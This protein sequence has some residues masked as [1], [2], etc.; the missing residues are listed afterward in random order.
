MYYI[1]VVITLYVQLTSFED[2]FGISDMVFLYCCIRFWRNLQ[3]QLMPANA[4]ADLQFDFFL[5]ESQSDN[6]WLAPEARVFSID[7]TD[8]LSPH[9]VDPESTFDIDYRDVD[10]WQASTTVRE[11]TMSQS[12]QSETSTLA[13]RDEHLPHRLAADYDSLSTDDRWGGD[14]TQGDYDLQVDPQTDLGHADY[15]DDIISETQYDIEGHRQSQTE[16]QQPSTMSETDA[17]TNKLWISS[18]SVTSRT[19]ETSTTVSD[20]GQPRQIN[21]PLAMHF[22]DY[23]RQ[24]SEESMRTTTPPLLLSTTMSVRRRTGGW[25][26]VDVTSRPTRASLASSSSSSSSACGRRRCPRFRPGV[27]RQFCQAQFGE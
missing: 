24:V 16:G 8:A 7:A 14:E 17:T 25:S 2:K 12:D 19:T 5:L 10:P 9:G 21:P 3:L 23:L 26:R 4:F 22:A 18:S 13:S 6:L 15:H 1:Y 27:R 20:S 11:R